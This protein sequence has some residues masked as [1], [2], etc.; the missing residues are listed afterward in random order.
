MA[1]DT[2][3]EFDISSRVTIH[4]IHQVEV[5]LEYNLEE[6][7]NTNNYKIES[8]FFIP[9]SLQVD[10]RTY[11]KDE[12]YTDLQNYIR[13]KTPSFSFK[14]ILDPEFT[15][16]PLNALEEIKKSMLAEKD[17]TRKIAL[18]NQAIKEL[19][20]LGAM[21]W[22]RMR[23]FKYFMRRKLSRLD[24]KTSPCRDLEYPIVRLESATKQGI[25]I[26]ERV[27]T[28][29]KEFLN[30][31]PQHEELFKYFKILE[32]SLSHLLEDEF[33]GI[34][35]STKDIMKDDK[36]IDG[37]AD[38]FKD[39]CRREKEKRAKSG[40]ILVIEEMD[41]K[42]GEEYLYYMGQFKKILSSVLY[43][44]AVR[45]EKEETY[46]HAVG[47]VAAFT[48][49]VIYFAIT[50]YLS[51][52]FAINS[53]PFIFLISL[54]YVFK[55]RIKDLIKFIYNPKVLSRFPDHITQLR[56]LSMA[57]SPNLGE[58]REKVFFAKRDKLDP[59]VLSYRDKTRP[60]SLFPEESQEQVLIYQKE[61]N[62]KTNAI[63]QHHSRTVNLTDI[64]RFNIRKY[65]LKMDDPEQMINYYDGRI[66]DFAQ[67]TGSRTYHLNLV[68]KYSKF[69]E[70]TEVIKYE[71]FRLVLNKWGIHRVE[72]I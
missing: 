24:P 70:K 15:G 62:I 39:F 34:L 38:N 47:A 40:S 1:E 60:A 3:R 25:E 8:Y 20:L 18:V 27:R 16:S 35:R 41:Q 7:Q 54:G 61:I 6:L 66:D 48:A 29:W 67:M 42:K 72:V 37:I 2:H 58:V 9:R 55:D 65:L 33:I 26:L 21:M 68:L 17:H 5:K 43:L 56:D 71:R 13:F 12:F 69:R 36:R 46:I 19:K 45:E 14:L 59:V 53:L 49:S 50:F 31:F 44:D 63:M 52:G 57:D 51:K 30:H 4:D 28:I 11:H 32:E 22:A 23:D 10:E 64:M